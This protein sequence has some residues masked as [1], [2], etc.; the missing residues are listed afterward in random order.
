[1]GSER[2]YTEKIV[3]VKDNISKK[4]NEVADDFKKMHK[5][6]SEAIKT[7]EDMLKNGKNDL[8]NMEK[9]I[10]VDKDLAPESK[11]RLDKEIEITR[12]ELQTKYEAINECISDVDIPA[13]NPISAKEKPKRFENLKVP[14]GR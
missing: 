13:F 11:E 1:M 12:L 5:Q 9:K 6:K 10:N 14:S 3:K 2:E 8:A 4:T 7:A